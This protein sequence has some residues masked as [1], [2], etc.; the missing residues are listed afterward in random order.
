VQEVNKNGV[1]VRD[2]DATWLRGT[3]R[4]E[5]A[6]LGLRSALMPRYRWASG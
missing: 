1:F 4:V 2:E 3:T 6:S 5:R